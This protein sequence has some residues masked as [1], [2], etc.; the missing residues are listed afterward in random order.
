MVAMATKSLGYGVH[1]Y[2]DVRAVIILANMEWASQHMWGAEISVTHRNIVARYKY[3]H[4]HDVVSIRE[5]L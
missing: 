1:V 2:S 5:N 4:V 3:N